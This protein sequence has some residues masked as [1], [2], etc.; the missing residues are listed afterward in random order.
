M[1]IF[2]YQGKVEPLFVPDTTNVVVPMEW[3]IQRPVRA[4]RYTKFLATLA[5]IVAPLFVPDVTQ[6]APLL[7]W[8]PTYADIVV[9]DRIHADRRP[10]LFAP[11]VV[12]DVTDPPPILSWSPVYSDFAK[13]SVLKVRRDPSMFAPVWVP[14]VTDPVP[15]R[16][17]APTYVDTIVRDRV[18]AD[19]RPYVEAPLFVPDTTQPVPA[20]SWTP[21][22]PDTL[23][24]DRV[25]APQKIA[26]TT[27]TTTPVIGT[28][29]AVD[30]L[31]LYPDRAGLR[32]IRFKRAQ[33]IAAPW[34]VPDVTDPSPLL[35]WAS[36]YPSSVSRIRTSLRT[37]F[38][39]DVI[40]T[41]SVA[42]DWLPLYRDLVRSRSLRSQDLFAPLFVPDVTQSVP[43]L[44]WTPD[45]PDSV[46]RPHL[47]RTV[48]Q[49]D[50]IL[51]SA[52]PDLSWAPL[53]AERRFF[54]RGIN[55]PDIVMPVFVPDVSVYG[56][57]PIYPD[58]AKQSKVRQT[59]GSYQ[60][61][62]PIWISDVTS[63][64]PA[65]AWSPIYPTASTRRV[66]RLRPDWTL[67]LPL[68]VPDVTTSVPAL[69]WLPIWPDFARSAKTRPQYRLY[70]SQQLL[71]PGSGVVAQTDVIGTYVVVTEVIGAYST[72]TEVVGSYAP[73]DDDIIGTY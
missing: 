45:Y 17:W 57:Q 56:L 72:T 55:R 12:P 62:A 16:A 59:H 4:S 73:S 35:A 19:R 38:L 5:I 61:V 1:A 36:I 3:E 53:Y 18:H 41:T 68:Y 58:F 31:P 29:S 40:T 51:I 69:S 10:S 11:V 44:S 23:V 26:Y 63:P 64:A 34:V 47:V 27:D 50:P 6:A 25:R 46:P 9:R 67:S 43:G 8:A 54:A 52:F 33:D 49:V 42:I 22:Y 13:Q 48:Q 28:V 21:N 2:Q 15:V 37:S 71:I 24:R 70:I 14:D 66:G 20:L 30:W 60:P 7:S 39:S 65:L 32:Q